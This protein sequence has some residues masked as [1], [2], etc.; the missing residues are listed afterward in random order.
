MINPLQFEIATVKQEVSCKECGILLEDKLKLKGHMRNHKQRNVPCDVCGK[1][2]LHKNVMA[3]HKQFVH[4][5]DYTYKCEFCGACYKSAHNLKVHIQNLHLKNHPY[6]CDRCEKGFFVMKQLDIHY[7][8]EHEDIRF[9]CE[10]CQKPF[11]TLRGVNKHVSVHDPTFKKTR[12][13]M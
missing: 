5:S 4:Y 8:V 10:F 1:L 13:H 9:T 11:K 7:K 12:I 6:K 2:F 3:K